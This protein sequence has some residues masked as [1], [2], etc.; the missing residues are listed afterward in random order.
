MGGKEGREEG[1]EGGAGEAEKN[2]GA[3][4]YM[5]LL[6]LARFELSFGEKR[7]GAHWRRGKGFLTA[8]F[9][10]VAWQCTANVPRMHCAP[11]HYNRGMRRL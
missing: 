3:C 4:E 7:L 10:S 5:Q 2:A 1:G 6:V 11:L 8:A 9:N